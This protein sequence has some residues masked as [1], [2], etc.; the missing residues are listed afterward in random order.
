MLQVRKCAVVPTSSAVQFRHGKRRVS[1][2]GTPAFIPD[3]E[4]LERV[5][6]PDDYPAGIRFVRGEF[7]IYSDFVALPG[8]RLDTSQPCRAV[9]DRRGSMRFSTVETCLQ[10]K[11]AAIHNI[12]HSEHNGGTQTGRNDS[13]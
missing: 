1:G 4:H 10:R 8:D 9:V 6:N 3:E 12:R 11:D 5:F 13:E 7:N 2:P